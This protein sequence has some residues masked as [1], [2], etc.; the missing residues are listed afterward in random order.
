MQLILPNIWV[1]LP[2]HQICSRAT[3]DENITSVLPMQIANLDK[4]GQVFLKNRKFTEKG[5]I[6]GKIL[7]QYYAAKILALRQGN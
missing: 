2:G 7:P 1:T 4:F 3:D 5:K 6:M